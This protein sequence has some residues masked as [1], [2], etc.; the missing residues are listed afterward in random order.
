MKQLL[1]LVLLSLVLVAIFFS[2]L[3]LI[4]INET[5]TENKWREYCGEQ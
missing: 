4:E 3:T 5:H 2:S 1:E